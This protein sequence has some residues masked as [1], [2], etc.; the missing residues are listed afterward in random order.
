MAAQRKYIRQLP[1]KKTSKNLSV[2]AGLI[3]TYERLAK[4]V[5]DKEIGQ[6]PDLA[7]IF[8]EA[9]CDVVEGT[10]KELQKI[11]KAAA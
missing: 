1:K 11:L 3:E 2:D 7:E 9:L 4:E 5:K 8:E 10:K 6:L